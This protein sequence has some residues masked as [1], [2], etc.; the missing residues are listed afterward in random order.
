MA[1]LGQKT[2]ELKWLD[3]KLR[4]P[5]DDCAL[6]IIRNDLDHVVKAFGPG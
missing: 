6:L 4:E 5:S 1:S 2:P 3:W